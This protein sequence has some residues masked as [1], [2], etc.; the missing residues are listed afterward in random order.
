MGP[1]STNAVKLQRI[2]EVMALLV[3]AHPRWEIVELLSKQWN[4]SERNVDHYIN[5]VKQL[6]QKNFTEETIADMDSKYDF[7]Y[8]EAL[9]FNDR[10]LAKQVIDSKAKLKG[11]SDKVEIRGTIDLRKLETIVI[12]TDPDK[13]E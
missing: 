6:I 10:A 7:L 4:C 11:I 9:R 2:K 3:T 5:A 1:K 12:N 13:D 8:Q